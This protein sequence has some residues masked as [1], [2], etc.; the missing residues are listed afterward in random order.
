MLL[1]SFVPNHYAIAPVRTHDYETFYQ[2]EL[3][4]RAALGYPPFGRVTQ[5]IVSS[6]DLEQA[7][8]AA[9]SLA[10]A[11]RPQEKR[12]VSSGARRL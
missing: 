7:Q 12:P 2:E 9:D 10:T 5:V 1:Q 4:H 8:K 3:G 11:V 6:E